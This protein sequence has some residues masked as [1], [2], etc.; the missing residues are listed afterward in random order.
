MGWHLVMSQQTI[1]RSLIRCLTSYC[2]MMSFWREPAN[3]H[4]RIACRCY[5]LSDLQMS[6]RWNQFLVIDRRVIKRQSLF[7]LKTIEA[8]LRP[9]IHHKIYIR[10]IVKTSLQTS[11]ICYSIWDLTK[12]Y[13]T[14]QLTIASNLSTENCYW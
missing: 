5:I 1:C 11:Y 9:C 8:I 13:N 6:Y 7:T 4:L 3:Y 14:Y 2:L 12:F 10:R